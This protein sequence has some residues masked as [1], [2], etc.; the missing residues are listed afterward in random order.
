MPVGGARVTLAPISACREDFLRMK[1]T[2]FDKLIQRT[3]SLVRNVRLC[4]ETDH[5]HG[6]GIGNSSVAPDAA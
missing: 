1:L 2:S 5:R 6:S 4:R 3:C